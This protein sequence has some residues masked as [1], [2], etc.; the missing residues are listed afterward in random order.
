[1]KS[2]KKALCFIL[3]SVLYLGN[4]ALDSGISIMK[5]EKLLLLLNLVH[6]RKKLVI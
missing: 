1:M 6:P 2:L 3:T 5:R 4:T